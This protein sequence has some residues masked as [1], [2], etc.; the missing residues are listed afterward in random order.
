MFTHSEI[1]RNSATDGTVSQKEAEQTLAFTQALNQLQADSANGQGR[2]LV[3]EGKQSLTQVIHRLGQNSSD[4][5]YQLNTGNHALVLAKKAIAG[6]SELLLL[7]S[8]L[9]RCGGFF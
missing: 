9:C 6:K 5:F 2:L 1:V 7:R 4:R 3:G 8:Q